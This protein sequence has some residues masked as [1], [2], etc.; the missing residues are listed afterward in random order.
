LG[1]STGF[2]P[3]CIRKLDRLPPRAAGELRSAFESFADD[4]QKFRGDIRKLKGLK[5]AWRIRWGG[6]RILF[7]KEKK[8][9]TAYDADDRKDVY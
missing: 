4:P 1:Y 6:Y 9:L 8:L 2:T 3:S 5:G 7:F